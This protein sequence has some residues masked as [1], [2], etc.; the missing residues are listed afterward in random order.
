VIGVDPATDR[1][2]ATMQLPAADLIAAGQGALW[3]GDLVGSTITRIDL[4]THE[5][6][7]PIELTSGVSELAVGE[8]K[9]WVLDSVAGTVTPVDPVTRQVGQEIRVGETPVDIAVGLGAVWVVCQDGT[10]W[11]IDPSL[12][13]V[14]PTV[15]AN[16][17]VP[18]SGL[19][20]DEGHKSIWLVIPPA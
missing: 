9:V 20:I 17:G 4:E 8:G 15:F 11:R 1:T 3:V 12:S 16:V 2:L 5:V 6:A 10:V 7:R 18:I 14:A 13:A 19:A